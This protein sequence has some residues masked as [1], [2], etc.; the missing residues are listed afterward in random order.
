M[1]AYLL[2]LAMAV[3]NHS[4]PHLALMLGVSMLWVEKMVES[5]EKTTSMVYQKGRCLV[6]LRWRDSLWV[7]LKETQIL[8][9][10]CF[11]ARMALLRL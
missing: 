10:N 6:V 5:S 4:V 8:K 11:F 2:V 9:A 7:V 1:R 3:S